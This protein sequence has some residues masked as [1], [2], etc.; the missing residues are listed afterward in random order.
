M[1]RYRVDFEV[2]VYADDPAGAIAIAA[3]VL[4]YSHP[5]TFTSDLAGGGYDIHQLRILALRPLPPQSSIAP[6]DDGVDKAPTP[7]TTPDH[8]N[9]ESNS[10]DSLELG[11]GGKARGESPNEKA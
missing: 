4:E 8:G 6:S 10:Q 11:S 7:G 5:E 2:L 3:S 9:E 1:T